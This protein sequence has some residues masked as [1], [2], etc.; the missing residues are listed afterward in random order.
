MVDVPSSRTWKGII[1]HKTHSPWRISKKGTR[2]E[3]KIGRDA[4][5]AREAEPGVGTKLRIDSSKRF[6]SARA[7]EP[8]ARPA[9][10]KNA[11]LKYS[12]PG[13]IEGS[14]TRS[15]HEYA[16]PTDDPFSLGPLVFTIIHIN[17]PER[18]RSCPKSH[19]L[20]EPTWL[21]FAAGQTFRIVPRAST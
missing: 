1:G 16:T 3:Y 18:T 2:F 5:S 13:R 8:P 17:C 15:G 11:R 10:R 6:A 12:R 21:H 20:R 7:P 4:F 19:A 9:L 14:Y